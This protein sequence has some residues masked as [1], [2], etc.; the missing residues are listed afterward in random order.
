M[1][2][3]P[4]L[5]TNGK[6]FT[7][8]ELALV[9]FVV[10]VLLF[11]LIVPMISVESKA[12]YVACFNQLKHIGLA[13]RIY[14]DDNEGRFP[15]EV[16]EEEGGSMEYKDNPLAAYGHF[17]VMSNLLSVPKVL[18]C[19]AD[20]RFEVKNFNTSM[21][22]DPTKRPAVG[23][24]VGNSTISYFVGVDASEKYPQML[25][26]GDRNLMIDGNDLSQGK[27]LMLPLTPEGARFN[28]RLTSNIQYSPS[29]HKDRG[30]VALADGSV[31]QWTSAALISHLLRTNRVEGE[32]MDRLAI[33]GAAGQ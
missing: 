32:P 28:N 14:A 12:P 3:D 33:P 17:Q 8:V 24:Q 15:M 22:P 18:V 31:E 25:L 20:K 21:E 9:L 7:L 30:N 5:H 23:P 13:F 10:F 19:P 29:I 26:V 2:I 11:L 6:A 1:K 4:K 16:P 27:S